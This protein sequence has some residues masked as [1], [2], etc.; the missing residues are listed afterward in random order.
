MILFIVR[1]FFVAPTHC[2]VPLS[3][4]LSDNLSAL[5]FGSSIKIPTTKHPGARYGAS[6]VQMPFSLLPFG[7]MT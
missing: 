6:P 2:L 7:E 4:M 5:D 1:T 3:R